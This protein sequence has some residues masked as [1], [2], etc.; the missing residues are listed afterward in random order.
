MNRLKRRTPQKLKLRALSTKKAARRAGG[1]RRVNV[2]RRPLNI[3]NKFLTSFAGIPELKTILTAI[4]TG[5]PSVEA[6]ERQREADR[7]AQREALKMESPSQ[8]LM[9]EHLREAKKDKLLKE[10]LRMKNYGKESILEKSGTEA[11]KRKFGEYK[12]AVEEAI[13]RAENPISN[14]IEGVPVSYDP[15]F[16]RYT[17]SGSGADTFIHFRPKVRY[18]KREKRVPKLFS[19]LAPIV[20]SAVPKEDV[21]ELTE[22]QRN[23]VSQRR[24]EFKN[25]FYQ[26]HG[27]EASSG[28]V[29]EAVPEIAEPLTGFGEYNVSLPIS[30]PLLVGRKI[31]IY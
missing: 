9:N 7:I 14:T 27:K 15:V 4:P 21:G 31:P 25:R 1:K 23:S 10:W 18:V 20:T 28:D 24:A 19:M 2:S 8:K 5:V 13:E 3:A 16:R 29:A 30:L 12:K 6:A 22:E 17:P 26:R 11:D